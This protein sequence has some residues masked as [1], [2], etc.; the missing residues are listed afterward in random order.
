M[1]CR[2]CAS[3]TEKTGHLY[4]CQNP[5]CGGVYWDKKQVKRLLNQAPENLASILRDAEVP[6]DLQGPNAYFVYVLRLRRAVNAV[7]VGMTG[8]HP[9]RRYLNHITNNRA[10][11]HARKNATA[12]INYEGP[13]TKT[14]AE[15]R[16]RELAEQLRLEG[17]LVRGG[18]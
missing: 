17:K 4:R 7:Y 13:M 18:H 1:S 8:H 3:P 9:Y 6:E 10:S 5:I 12:L 11:R 16:E 15:K 2:I 14:Q